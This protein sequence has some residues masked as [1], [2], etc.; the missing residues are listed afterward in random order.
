MSWFG[1]LN[2]SV[3]PVPSRGIPPLHPWQCPLSVTGD[4]AISATRRPRS[5]PVVVSPPPCLSYPWMGNLWRHRT[6]TAAS[7]T[8]WQGRGAT[9][10]NIQAIP[11]D[12][13]A[14]VSH[15]MLESLWKTIRS[16]GDWASNAYTAYV[17]LERPLVARAVQLMADRH[18]WFE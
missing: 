15:M 7:R 12:V 8:W 9:I 18:D 6:S 17:L 11:W 16:L 14:H 13:E 5:L 1:P 2:N 3:Q 10:R 4:D